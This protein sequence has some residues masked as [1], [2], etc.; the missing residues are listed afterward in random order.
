MLRLL[1]TVF[2]L[3]MGLVVLGTFGHDGSA[4]ALVNIAIYPLLLLGSIALHEGGH[5][6]SALALGLEVP[7]IE[8]GVGRR[9]R[10]WRWGRTVIQLNTMPL[11]GLTFIGARTTE[12]LRWRLWL[13]VAVGPLVSAGILIL[14]LRWAPRLGLDDILFPAV[15]VA[16]RF[17]A[18]D[19][20][21]CSNFWMLIVNLVPLAGLTRLAGPSDGVQLIRLPSKPLRELRES[22]IVAQLFEAE[23]LRE[24]R[25]YDRAQELL[26]TAR[27]QVPES[28][29]LQNSL[30]MLCLDRGLLDDA[31]AALAALIAA[32][33]DSSLTKLIL[34]NNLAWIDY[35][36]RRD[37]LRAEAS[38]YSEAV[39]ERFPRVAWALSTRGAVLVWHG[40][41]SAALPMLEEAFH[42]SS[43]N[44]SR[45][46][47]A[48][49]LAQALIGL[50][51]P[52]EAARWVTRARV[53]DPTCVLLDEAE[54]AL[55]ATDQPPT[56]SVVIP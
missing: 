2:S 35:R 38:A 52:K 5:A 16:N 33:A 40:R 26:E 14:T 11:L 4:W 25:H 18:R 7:R 44:S 37:D 51:R 55:T 13:S 20:L 19:L 15:P 39:H 1:I 54:A 30:A 34:K 12:G 31:R 56:A 41:F 29:G 50:R 23:Y 17:A 27:L 47:T 9:L 48:C 43:S 45:A 32:E 6:L 46:E 42:R 10:R 21:A 36:L 22:L 8:I 49:V 53:V 24:E 28:R 3:P